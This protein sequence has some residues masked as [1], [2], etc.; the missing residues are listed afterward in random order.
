M[1][2]LTVC[3]PCHNSIENMHKSIASCLLL[4]DE[5]EVLIVDNHSQDETLAL[6]R[7]YEAQYP[8]TVKVIDVKEDEFV[9]SHVI[10]Q[11]Q[12]LY[13]KLLKSGDYF[14]QPSLVSVIETLR[15][16]MRIQANLDL[17]ITDY[18]YVSHQKKDQKIT[19]R[20]VFPTETLFAWHGIKMLR[21]HFLVDMQAVIVKTCILKNMKTILDHEEFLPVNIVYGIVPYVKS[22]YYLPTYLYCC[23][24]EKKVVL[25]EL[26]DYIVLLKKL[27]NCYDVF[28][29]KSRRQR[30][31]AIDQLSKIYIAIEYL[32]FKNNEKTKKTELDVYLQES[33]YKLYKAVTKNLFGTL[34]ALDN[35]KASGLIDKLFEK[36][37][38][39]ID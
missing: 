8:E 2:L 30:N 34:L 33:H 24:G 23:E 35:N 36:I 31:F 5:I 37:Y 6:A 22:M 18:K 25:H 16:F 3:I 13:F 11:C 32:V 27:W 38:H 12:G 7:E 15:D 29:L 21:R 28:A 9:L 14:D 1:K 26:D 4:K 17:L 10:A 39:D 19:Y 20:T